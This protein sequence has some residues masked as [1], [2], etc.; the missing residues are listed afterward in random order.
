MPR[1]I[2]RANI[3]PGNSVV[4]VRLPKGMRNPSPAVRN[5]LDELKTRQRLTNREGCVVALF[6]KG[7][8]G[9]VAAQRCDNRELKAHNKRQCRAKA[10]K[11]SK[12]YKRFVRCK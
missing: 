4:A 8:G 6:S 11:G 12:N 1:T 5:A 10:P 2:I 3:G 7:R 9:Y